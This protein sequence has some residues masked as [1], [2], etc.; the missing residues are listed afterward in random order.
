M[1]T[2]LQASYCKTPVMAARRGLLPVREW[3][4]RPPT[5]A[6]PSKTETCPTPKDEEHSLLLVRTKTPSASKT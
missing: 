3:N 2:A 6:H 4:T 1:A 5:W